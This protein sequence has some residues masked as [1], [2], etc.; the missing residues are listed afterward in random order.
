[1][2]KSEMGKD[3][4]GGI[5][6]IRHAMRREGGVIENLGTPEASPTEISPRR[7]FVLTFP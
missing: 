3:A 6:E 5:E 4:R 1:M 2:L 7:I